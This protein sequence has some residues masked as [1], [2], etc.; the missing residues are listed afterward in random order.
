MPH[1]WRE[2]LKPVL[3][4]VTAEIL[5]VPEDTVDCSFPHDPGISTD[6]YPTARVIVEDVPL[7]RDVY[8]SENSKRLR[9]LAQDL[10]V[11]C[12]QKLDLMRHTDDSRVKTFIKY[13]N[14]D[15]D[16]IYDTR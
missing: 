14:V 1:D 7:H 10:A 15:G 9:Q 8:G 5:G 12:K 3:I 11:A 4:Q 2:Q 6:P 16:R 13:H